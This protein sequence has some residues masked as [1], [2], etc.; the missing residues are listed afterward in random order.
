MRAGFKTPRIVIFSNRGIRFIRRSERNAGGT[1]GQDLRDRSSG[2]F[3]GVRLNDGRLNR[4]ARG[5]IGAKTSIFPPGRTVI[6]DMHAADIHGPQ[7]NY[8]KSAA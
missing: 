6:F 4:L 8:C 2:C 1:L 7:G 3:F 5:K